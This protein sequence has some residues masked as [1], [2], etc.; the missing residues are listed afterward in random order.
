MVIPV[1]TDIVRIIEIFIQRLQRSEISKV[2]KLQCQDNMT[3]IKLMNV[4]YLHIDVKLLCFLSQLR[5]SLTINLDFRDIDITLT[6]LW[7]NIVG[8]VQ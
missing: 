3:T 4:H 8:Q 2:A 7:S 1:K 6:T 5:Y